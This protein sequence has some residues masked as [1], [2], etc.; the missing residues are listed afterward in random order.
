MDVRPVLY[1][2]GLFLCIM[3]L[4][5]VLPLLADIYW[6]S[7]DWKVFFLSII[8]TAFFGGSLVLS[9]SGHTMG[10]NTKQAIL[11]IILSWLSLVLFASLPFTLSD[12]DMSFTDA[13]FEAMS[14]LT[15]TGSTVIVGLDTAPAGILLWRA[16][17]QWLGGIGI[18]IMAMSVLP[19][20]KVGGMQIFQTE[21]SESEKVLPRTAQLAN[22]IG[23]I[24]IVLTII[25]I[26]AYMA[27]GMGTFDAVAHALTTI[28]TGGFST[29]DASLAHFKTPSA[30]VVAV[31]FMIMGGTPFVLYLK[32]VRGNAAP[33]FKD[34][35][36]RTFLS[37][38]LI[39]SS[40]IILSLT[41]GN[42]HESF[43][44]IALEVVFNVTS[45][46][47]GTGFANSDYMLW[48]TFPVALL[49]FLM[50]VGGCAGSTSCGI[51]IFRFQVFFAIAKVQLKNLVHPSAIFK[52]TYNGKPIP[53]DVPI[54]VMSFLFLFALTFAIVAIAL[55][56][57]GLDFMT[58]MSGAA[59][60]IANVGPGMGDIIGPT[61]NFSTLPDSAKWI[62][63][64]SML[65]GRLE[66]LTVLVMLHPNFWKN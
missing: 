58:A 28:S 61:G 63:S 56:L 31:I 59:T 7:D 65:L 36:V 32:F 38:I 18:I 64:A 62:L 20:L 30:E 4:S 24:Y 45:L 37:I 25:C 29:Y 1:I 21:L 42:H 23:L 16:L 51:K 2:I 39:V 40:L 57:V 19:F 55:S 6:G 41:L 35:Q 22:S 26:L 15:T 54:S 33:L 5:L 47:T 43:S 17:L 11:L 50:V 48:G 12:L 60:S 13:F 66:I 52:A 3:S 27:T 44:K 9:N 46:L 34:T 49:F 8:I 10:I 53:K 14:G